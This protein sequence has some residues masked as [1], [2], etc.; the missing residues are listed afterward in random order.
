MIRH[1]NPNIANF[2]WYNPPPVF[3]HSDRRLGLTA[4]ARVGGTPIL[5]GWSFDGID[6]YLRFPH[7]EY[8]HPRG[9]PISVEALLIARSNIGR[10]IDY[11]TG[12]FLNHGSFSIFNGVGYN[13][14]PPMNI[15]LNIPHWAHGIAVPYSY[16]AFGANGV[17]AATSLG[18]VWSSGNYS[19]Y[20]GSSAVPSAYASM[21]LYYLRISRRIVSPSESMR[22]R[23]NV[24]KNIGE[25]CR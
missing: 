18:P 23:A 7:S 10:F 14:S 24:I 6:D 25:I 3:P 1:F 16:I 11:G 21:D 20:L 17:Y 15:P 5:H 4:N 2:E 8:F 19:L 9:G 22:R 13:S 12:W